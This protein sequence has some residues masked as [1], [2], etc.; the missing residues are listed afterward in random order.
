MS[1]NACQKPTDSYKSSKNSAKRHHA[2]KKKKHSRWRNKQRSKNRGHQLEA[3]H[4]S[5]PRHLS[6]SRSVFQP[7]SSAMSSES[8]ARD[9]AASFWGNY[10]V[11]MEWQSKHFV[12]YWKSRCS[13]L[14][15]E[16]QH[17]YK[18][19]EALSGSE[20]PDQNIS[21]VCQIHI[22]LI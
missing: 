7:S 22:R 19:I 21:N 16:N 8:R 9:P 4:F 3:R 6:D 18:T 14:E 1:T 10:K 17:L 2:I 11:A 12:N 5:R 20:I 13:A 15:L